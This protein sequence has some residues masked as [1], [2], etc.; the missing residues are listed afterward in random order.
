MPIINIFTIIVITWI[1][2]ENR[3]SPHIEI[4]RERYVLLFYGRKHRK[5]IKLFRI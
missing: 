5:F 3:L 4:T 1:I 2:I